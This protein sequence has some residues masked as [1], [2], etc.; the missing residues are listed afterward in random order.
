[1][2]TAISWGPV[3]EGHEPNDQHVRL[4]GV[5][6]M[7]ST[8]EVLELKRKRNITGSLSGEHGGKPF[9]QEEC[10]T[11]IA[12]TGHRAGLS[13]SLRIVAMRGGSIAL[14]LLKARAVCAKVRSYGSV[15][16]AWS[17]PRPYRDLSFVAGRWHSFLAQLQYHFRIQC[18]D[19]VI[20]GT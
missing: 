9:G 20:F 12:R 15:R 2:S 16:G 6:R 4:W 3:G 8:D 19:R 10:A 18:S 11:E 17:N 7:G 14:L 13:V 1:M 5:G